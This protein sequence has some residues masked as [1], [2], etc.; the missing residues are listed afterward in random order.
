MN[1]APS[2]GSGAVLIYDGGTTSLIGRPRWPRGTRT[3]LDITHLCTHEGCLY[4]AVVLDRYARQA[5]DPVIPW[6]IGQP[7]TTIRQFGH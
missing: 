7:T 2:L 4:L 5:L 1:L 6:A 3:G